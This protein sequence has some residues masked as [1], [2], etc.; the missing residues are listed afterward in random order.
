MLESARRPRARDF[1]SWLPISHE[2]LVTRARVRARAFLNSKH[3]K[4]VPGTAHL[5]SNRGA[6]DCQFLLLQGVGKY[7]WIKAEG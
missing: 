3:S 7:D 6:T 1:H 4:I 2:T 5:L